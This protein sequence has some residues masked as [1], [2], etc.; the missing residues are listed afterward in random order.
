MAYTARVVEYFYATVGTPTDEA[1][2][3]IH[4]LSDLGVNF[5]A[6]NSVPLGPS[7]TQLT[8]FPED[9]RRLQATAAGAKLLLEGPHTAVLVQGD[10]EI[11]A[12]AHIHERVQRHGVEVYATTGITDGRGGYGYILYVRAGLAD[13]AVKALAGER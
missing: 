12:L 9:P 11:G 10:D 3:M 5:L 1:Y 8:L 4:S 7:T 6:L 2:A 13:Q